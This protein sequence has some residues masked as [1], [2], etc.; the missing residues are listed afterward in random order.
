MRLQL[1]FELHRKQ[2]LTS[3]LRVALTLGPEPPPI[4]DDI[5]EYGGG[6]EDGEGDTHGDEDKEGDDISDVD[7][8]EGIEV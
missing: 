1:A 3:E 2:Q 7:D 8:S 6:Y 5:E 4:Q